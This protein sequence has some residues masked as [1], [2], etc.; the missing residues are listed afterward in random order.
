[1]IV[2]YYKLR[3]NSKNYNP[4]DMGCSAG[5]ISINLAKDL[6]KANPN[7]YAVVVS[8]ENITLN[9]YFGNE[10]SML[11]CNCI[12]RMGGAAVLLTNKRRDRARSKYE[13][14]HMVR[15]HKGTDDKNYNFVY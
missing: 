8:M 15:T 2:N 11:F 7:S 5:L 1:M 9:W 12:F 14:V 13:L 10:R 6:L 4:S 3:T